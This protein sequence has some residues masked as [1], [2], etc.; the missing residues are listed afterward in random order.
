MDKS[1]VQETLA[2]LYLRLN[3][4]FVSGFIVHAVDG[5]RTEMDVL[6][7]RFPRHQEPEREVQCCGHLAIPANHVDFLV[8]EV[9]GGQG[10]VNFNARF[11]QNPGAI[12]TVLRRF[13]AFD[14]AEIPGIMSAI[15]LLLDPANLRNAPA[16]P[17]LDVTLAAPLGGHTAKLRFVA[18]ASEQERPAAHARPYVFADDLLD[19]VWQCFRPEQQRPLCDDHYNYELWGPQFVT[20]VRYFK[21]PNRRTA[22]TMGDIYREYG[23]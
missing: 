16:F 2:S 13:G 22:G 20:M 18:F 14:D 6:A 8:G 15:P 1:D 23:A 10:A 3:G 12:Q 21:D 9:K 17:E 19:F 4:Y 11:R 5:A 7:V